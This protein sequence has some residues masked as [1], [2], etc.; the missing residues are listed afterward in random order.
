IQL[1][2]ILATDTPDMAQRGDVR[3]GGGPAMSLY[4]F[5]GRGTLNGTIPHPALVALFGEAA[6]GE[7]IALQKS[8]HV[9]LLTD[10]SYVQLVNAGVASID[11]GYP[12]RGT[13]SSLEICD[14]SDLAGLARLLAAGLGRIDESFSLDRD[15]YET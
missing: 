10:S 6:R 13:H 8:A 9:G 15:R 3:L 1:D 2:I 4:S 11:L 14:L 7:G 12:A 5:H